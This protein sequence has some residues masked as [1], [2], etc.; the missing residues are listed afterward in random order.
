MELAENLYSFE[1]KELKM[2]YLLADLQKQLLKEK[3]DKKNIEQY[4]KSKLT[5][6]DTVKINNQ[7]LNDSYKTQKSMVER[8]KR[9]LKALDLEAT[10][11]LSDNSAK[12]AQISRH[13]FQADRLSLTIKKL[14][15]SVQEKEKSK[16]ALMVQLDQTCASK[17]RLMDQNKKLFLKVNQMQQ[18]LVEL[19]QTNQNP[20]FID[21]IKQKLG[22]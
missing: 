6:L 17:D 2:T 22:W 5:N 21:R 8:L 4:Y 18:Q 13:E 19:Q 9:E 7:T 14:E 11:L 10:Q 15:R 20:G 3:N 16:Q 12:D 1:N